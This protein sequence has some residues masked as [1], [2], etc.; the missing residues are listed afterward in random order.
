MTL[1]EI[2]KTYPSIDSWLKLLPEGKVNVFSGKVEI[3]QRI[4]T[5]LALIVSDQ[6]QVNIDRVVVTSGNTDLT[7]D[8]GYTAA[9][10]SMETAG[11]A[12]RIIA[13]EARCVLL[14]LA[15]KRLSCAEEDLSV[16]DGEIVCLKSKKKISYWDLSVG[17]GFERVVSGKT[18]PRRSSFAHNPDR[19]IPSIDLMKIVTGELKYIQDI[20]LPGMVYA[21]VIRPLN[22]HSGLV[23]ADIERA[24][25]ADGV[26]D[27]ICN[28]SFL[29]VI[30][31]EEYRVVKAAESL[32]KSATWNSNIDLNTSNIHEQLLSRPRQ[33]ISEKRVIDA[34][35][36]REES[37]L[38]QDNCSVIEARYKRPYLMHGSIG[39]S[40]AVAW[41]QEDGLK[42]WSSTQG[43]YPLRYALSEVLKMAVADITIVH[44]QGAGCYGHN[45]ADDAALDAALLAC[46]CP[47]RPVQVIWSREDEHR[48][49]P[50][51]S[52]MVVDLKASIGTN[53]TIREWNHDVYSDSHVERAGEHP[54]GSQ[55]LA[56]WHLD[57]PY[58]QPNGTPPWDI[59]TGIGFNAMPLYDIPYCNVSQHRVEGLPLRVS[60]LRSLGAYTNVFSIESFMDELANQ[61]GI[62]PL[63]FR[64]NHLA[65]DNRAKDV[66]LAVST[67]SN[68]GQ[69][70]EGEGLGRGVAFDRYENQKTY[71]AVVV[72][73]EVD[74]YGHIKCLKAAIAGDAGEIVDSDG[75]R[76]QLEGGFLQSLSW[77]LKEEVKYDA[78]GI[79][80][81]DWETY[82]LLTYSEVP[83]ITTI[84]ID[85]PGSPFLGCGEAMQGPTSAAIANAV[86]DAVGIR[87]R[88]TPF[89]PERVQ[90]SA[91][92][93]DD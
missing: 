29:A 17:E 46:A 53:G 61:A 72:D 62:D 1:P 26:L 90:S 30:G 74:D 31:D 42:V 76:C 49:E 37:S 81:I 45:G 32:R 47:G 91:W 78:N 67:A 16:S 40:A 27:I 56:S 10:F 66:L 69:T 14:E 85:R 65:E 18:V 58:H 71:T 13:A 5:A 54:E 86:F 55:L 92:E 83:D 19:R 38:D 11:S 15:A 70:L 88:Q 57:Q 33:T 60:A 77:T 44:V 48:W 36:M 84:L 39:P 23:S 22:Y 2:L 59:F 68:W 7:P 63:E 4:K 25:Q 87:L 21:R 89:T 79:T 75:L 6:L 52:A 28:G 12:L 93:A 34:D 41:K 24:K 50:Y 64:L 20:Q 35:L 43:V 73:V 8:E 51:G 3:G 82:P 9:S 80:S